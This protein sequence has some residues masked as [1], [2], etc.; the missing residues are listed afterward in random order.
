METADLREAIV[1]YKIA[2]RLHR[3]QFNKSKTD[4]TRGLID[5]TECIKL[6]KKPNIKWK[7]F[8][9]EWYEILVKT[10]W[11]KIRPY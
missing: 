4:T 5:R 9:T 8:I 7:I 2:R 6:V 10:N 1:N 11:R 3:I